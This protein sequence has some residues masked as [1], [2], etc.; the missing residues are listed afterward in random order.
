MAVGDKC[1][2]ELAL[3]SEWAKELMKI[4]LV[5]GDNR[6]LVKNTIVIG[7]LLVRGSIRTLGLAGTMVVQMSMACDTIMLRVAVIYG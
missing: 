4:T 2:C 3:R 1:S 6:G 5:I 7:L